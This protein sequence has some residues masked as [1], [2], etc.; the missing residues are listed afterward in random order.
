MKYLYADWLAKLFVNVDPE[1]NKQ[2]I[3][4]SKIFHVGIMIFRA[5]LRGIAN[6]P[7]DLRFLPR[8][9]VAEGINIKVERAHRQ[10]PRG[11]ITQSAPFVYAVNCR[12]FLYGCCPV[13]FLFFFSNAYGAFHP[14][15]RLSVECIAFIFM[16]ELRWRRFLV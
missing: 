7:C 4:M 5:E 1:A 12:L 14:F 3:P 13:F 2:L 10:P 15:R 9:W 11:S 6:I 8:G 16:C